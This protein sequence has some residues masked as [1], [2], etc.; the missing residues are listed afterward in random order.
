MADL[1]DDQKEMTLGQLLARVSRLVGGRMRA[2]LEAVGLPHAYGMILFRL[3]KKDGIPQNVLAKSLHITPPTATSTLQRMERDGWIQRRRDASDQRIVR[4]YL[5][6]KSEM[7]RDEARE[8]FRDLDRELAAV[9]T[10]EERKTLVDSL[11]KVET[12]LLQNMKW[13]SS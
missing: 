1:K 8:A 4:V 7:V 6:K 9:I 2:R 12:R 10:D 3:W 13:I 5:T 11:Q